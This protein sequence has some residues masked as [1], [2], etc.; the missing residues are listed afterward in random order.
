MSEQDARV[1]LS[2]IDE[3]VLSLQPER[4]MTIFRALVAVDACRIEQLAGEAIDALDPETLDDQGQGTDGL[5][6]Q[7]GMEVFRDSLLAVLEERCPEI[8]PEIEFDIP[9]WIEGNA[10]LATLAHI[11]L[12]EA[13]LPAGDPLAYRFVIE[14]H[15]RIDLERYE[16]EQTAVLLSAW[17]GIEAAIRERLAQSPT[18]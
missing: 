17:A 12:M 7:A 9:T 16:A 11:G 13:A 6:H 4:I 5:V 2:G 18:G 14:L 1:I 8:E 10:P 15:Q 3:R